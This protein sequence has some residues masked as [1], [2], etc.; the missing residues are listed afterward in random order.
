ME[1]FIL[2]I[3]SLLWTCRADD[4]DG[5]VARTAID[6]HG[7]KSVK[8]GCCG[9]QREEALDARKN[10]ESSQSCTKGKEIEH[11]WCNSK[12]SHNKYGLLKDDNQAQ[13]LK[14]EKDENNKRTNSNVFILIKGG[15]FVIGTDKPFI[16]QDAE[17][18][19]RKVILSNFYIHKFEV[20][21]KEFSTFIKQ[22]H[23]LT[24]VSSFFFPSY[25]TFQSIEVTSLKPSNS[26]TKCMQ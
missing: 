20:S 13:N 25:Q 23:H 19:A 3:A 24:E 17:A 11:G 8:A 21:N 10:K 18:P 4:S 26:R 16:P 6:D 9:T 22:T 12:D 14:E 1:I 15:T 7:P 2:V 5:N